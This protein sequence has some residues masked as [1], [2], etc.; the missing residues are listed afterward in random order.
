MVGL[1]RGYPQKTSPMSTMVP[2]IVGNL[3]REKAFVAVWPGRFGSVS[4]S[5]RTA[6]RWP[7]DQ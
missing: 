6:Q 5:M 3:E 1:M 7:C 4:A 2:L